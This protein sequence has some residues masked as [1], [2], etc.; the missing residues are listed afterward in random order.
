ME[1]AELDNKKASL[2]REFNELS[3][4]KKQLYSNMD[5][6]TPMSVEEKALNNKMSAISSEMNSIIRE[7]RNHLKTIK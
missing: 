3:A 7:K 4:I 2:L 6:E 5:I 1:T